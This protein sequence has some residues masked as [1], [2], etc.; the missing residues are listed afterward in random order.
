MSHP[1]GQF[2]ILSVHAAA[3]LMHPSHET[4]GTEMLSGIK[5]ACGKEALGDN[6]R[7]TGQKHCRLV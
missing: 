6:G 7:P 2:K 3:I 1:E 5:K 4:T